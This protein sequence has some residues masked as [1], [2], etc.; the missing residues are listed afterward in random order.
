MVFD[1]PMW[2]EGLFLTL[3]A[4]HGLTCNKAT[5]DRFGWDYLVELDREAVAGRAHDEQSGSATGRVQVKSKTGGKPSTTLKL[6]NALRFTKEPNPCFV[7]LVWRPKDQ[8]C[9]RIYARHF[10]EELMALSLRRAR[11]ADRDGEGALNRIKLPVAFQDSDDHTDDLIPWIKAII[12]S[13]RSEYSAAKDQ[14]DK[15]LGYDSVRAGG[16]ITLKYSELQNFV[17]HGVGLRDEV[18][19]DN[20]IVHN[21]RFD[22][23][24][25]EPTFSGK[26]DKVI[27]RVHPKPALMTIT[28]WDGHT[29]AFPGDFRSFRMPGAVANVSRASFI[30]PFITASIEASGRMKVDYRYASDSRIP[31]D[32]LLRIVRFQLACRSP[33]SVSLAVEGKPVV[34]ATPL[35]LEAD[36]DDW[37]DWFEMTLDVLSAIRR[38]ADRVK[39]SLDDLSMRYCELTRFVEAMAPG[40][41]RLEVNDVPDGIG[42]VLAKNLLTYAYAT[43]ANWTFMGIARR[44]CLSQERNGDNLSFKFGDPIMLEAKALKGSADKHIPQLKARFAALAPRAG[45]GVVI[46]NDGD[47]VAADSGSG[48]VTF[49]P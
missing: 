49:S 7:V 26:P 20:I 13:A 6:S 23:D 46:V 11:E 8:T 24:A 22:I 42:A 47:I 34:S 37:F 32:D 29:A 38:P 4:E 45:G 9:T 44:P 18:E 1:L 36:S 25:R 2:A 12:G 43:V 30:C 17:D 5:Q 14:L 33:L 48:R 15:T 35:V 41:V 27:M 40:D 16:V 28:G 31:F 3:C 39:L 21:R 10:H 19:I